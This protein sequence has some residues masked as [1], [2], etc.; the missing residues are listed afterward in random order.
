ME[1]TTGRILLY[2]AGYFLILFSLIPL[3][4]LDNWYFRIFEY[5]RF[6]KLLINLL[7]LLLALIFTDY[8]DTH[9]LVFVGLLILNSLYLFYQIWPYTILGK[10]QIVKSKVAQGTS[11]FKLFIANVYQDNRD[12]KSCLDSIASNDPD[13]ILLVE[14]DENWKNELDKGLCPKYPHQIARPLSNTYGMI[15]YSRLELMSTEVRYLVSEDIPSI[16]CTVRLP[17]GHVFKLY[18]IHPQP[19]VPTENPRS[20]ERDAEIL[21]VAKDALKSKVPVVVAGDLNDVAWSYTTELFLKVSKLLDPRRGRGFF[22]TFH[23]HHWYLRWPLDHVFCSVHFELCNLRRLPDIGS[24]HFPILI[25][26]LLS[27]KE[28]SENKEHRL[29]ANE[30]D[31]E[32][33]NEKIREAG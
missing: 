24:D 33:A 16:Y 14:T 7:I 20:T 13:L 8:N 4:R 29:Q 2:A 17:S 21:L 10:N 23:A 9:N 18:G 1:I 19:P 28:V 32:L 27:D 6:Q 5:P 11:K 25:E 15:L 12:V 3:V 26:L 31:Y 30:R 22:N